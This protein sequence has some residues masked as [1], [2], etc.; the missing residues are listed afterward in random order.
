MLLS[1]TAIFCR[2]LSSGVS[3]LLHCRVPHCQ[4]HP[5]NL[6]KFRYST[7]ACFD[8]PLL[9]VLFFLLFLLVSRSMY[10]ILVLLLLVLLLLVWFLRSAKAHSITNIPQWAR[11]SQAQNSFLGK[12]AHLVQRWRTL[13]S[14]LPEMKLGCYWDGIYPGTQ[15]CLS[16]I[17]DQS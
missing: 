14:L 6:S 10:Y 2:A 5:Q 17:S 11:R 12:E 3:K 16:C 1:L 13:F 8:I 4:L 9:L 7:M 15:W